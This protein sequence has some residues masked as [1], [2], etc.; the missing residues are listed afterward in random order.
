MRDKDYCLKTL[1]RLGEKVFSKLRSY[2]MKAK[3][4]FVRV[5][6]R[7]DGQQGKWPFED[8]GFQKHLGFNASSDSE[9]LPQVYQLF[10]EHLDTSR[11]V[12]LVGVGVSGLRKN[13]NLSLFGESVK[14]DSLFREIDNLKELYGE[15]II[16]AG[17]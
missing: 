14:R 9:L 6:Y 10:L 11:S 3:T 13:Y 2:D 4:V 16:K 8:F 12:R 1:K 15:D 7:I 17:V 5:R